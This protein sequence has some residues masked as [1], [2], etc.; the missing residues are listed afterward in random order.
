[1]RVT[2]RTSSTVEMIKEMRMSA[3]DHEGM[4]RKKLF[5]CFADELQQKLPGAI[6]KHQDI[7]RQIVEHDLTLYVETEKEREQKHETLYK[8]LNG[9]DI[10]KS[11]LSYIF[12][13]VL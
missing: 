13:E 4:I 8:I 11:V 2:S 7:M 12:R 1:M 10:P 9:Y 3:I 5:R 6:T